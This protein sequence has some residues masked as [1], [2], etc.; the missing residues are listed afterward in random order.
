[1]PSDHGT[2]NPFLINKE[3]NRILETAERDLTRANDYI[4]PYPPFAPRSLA[5]PHPW[6]FEIRK[7]KILLTN[8]HTGESIFL[9]FCEE[10]P[11]HS[12]AVQGS[13]QERKESARG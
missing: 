9:R 1:M 10:S 2:P 3:W 5:L 12:A 7:G 8:S 11:V 6:F 4:R 13:I